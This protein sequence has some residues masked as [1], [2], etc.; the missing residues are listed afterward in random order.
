MESGLNGTNL[1][2]MRFMLSL[3]SLHGKDCSYNPCHV[4]MQYLHFHHPWWSYRVTHGAV[5]DTSIKSC[6]EHK[7]IRNKFEQLYLAPT[8]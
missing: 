7:F 6:L 5:A 4:T 3:R 8:G 2:Y 1:R